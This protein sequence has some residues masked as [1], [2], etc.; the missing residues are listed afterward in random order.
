MIAILALLAAAQPMATPQLEPLAFLAGHCWEGRFADGKVDTHCFEPVYDGRYLRDRHAVTGAGS[1]YAGETLY[2]WDQA[3]GRVI[4]TYWNTSGGVSRGAMVPR[5]SVL[6]F[7]DEVYRGRD[8]QETRIATAW[9]RIGDDAYEARTTSAA[10]PTGNR[11]VRYVRVAPA[12]TVTEATAPDGTRSLAH[13]I[14]VPAQVEQVYAAFATPEGWRSWAVPHA[15]T[16]PA[17]PDH[18]ETSYAPHA[19]LGDPANIR[20]HF[21]A[22]VPN[23]LVVFRTVRTPPGFP[24][25]ET[26]QRTL[27]VAEFEPVAGGTRV[28]LTGSGY[29]ATEAGNAL[30]AFFREGNRTSLEQLRARFVTGPVDWAARRRAGAQ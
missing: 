3:A 1:T 15:W 23:R 2:A 9:H 5:G 14:V 19:T 12:V 24:H 28:R 25:A 17:A 4:Y 30:L 18:I 20:Q 27:G 6:D 29:P 26:Y 21:L 11:T 13:E 10:N 7:G 8:G 22:R 16:D